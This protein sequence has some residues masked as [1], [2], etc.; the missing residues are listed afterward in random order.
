MSVT[1]TDI[2]IDEYLRLD[3]A[4]TRLLAR[5][6]TIEDQI[7][8]IRL[9]AKGDVQSKSLQG[10]LEQRDTIQAAIDA[11]RKEVRPQVQAQLERKALEERAASM[12]RLRTDKVLF[13]DKV[14]TLDE[15]V[16]R[17]AAVVK[18][19]DS[20]IG[21]PG[22][23]ASDLEVLGDEVAQ[24]DA[25]AKRVA[26]QLQIMRVEPRPPLR[27]S[28]LEPAEPPRTKNF[29][30]QTKMASAA[31][32]GALALAVFGVSWREYRSRRIYAP[33]DVVEGLGMTLIG[34]LPA[35]PANARIFSLEANNGRAHGWQSVL[36]EAVDA[37]RAQLLRAAD[38]DGLRVVMITSAN[39]GEGKTSLAGQ[40]AASLARAWRKTLLIDGDLRH[41]GIHRQFDMPQE[42]GFSDVLRGELECDDA[43]RPTP[44]PRLWMMPAGQCDAHATQALAQ[45]EVR[46]LLNRLKEQYDF[47]VLDSS[48]VL[49]VADALSLGQHVDAV[50]FSILRNVSRLPAVQAS[51][52]RLAS[53]GIR[54]L[55]TVVLGTNAEAG[56]LGYPYPARANP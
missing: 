38:R 22:K 21:Q 33:A 42:P 49:P 40:L 39:S 24:M 20:T 47:I 12:V 2:A 34:T 41:P 26:D 51:Q 48:P 9:V 45:K 5:L 16:K 10:P 29:Q 32:F 43:I 19:L 46:I 1:V 53:L 7:Q 13:E 37:L 8:Q 28:V 36:S 17:Q 56:N 4:Q 55:G 23:P 6:N 3:P 15:E 25:T 35:L 50:V 30:M 54:M 44:L 11:R 14:K 27:A 18:Q 52:Q 31:G